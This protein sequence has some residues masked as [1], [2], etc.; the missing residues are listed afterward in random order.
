MSITSCLEKGGEWVSGLTMLTSHCVKKATDTLPAHPPSQSDILA[1][2]EKDP[3]PKENEREIDQVI[4]AARF[5]SHLLGASDSSLKGLGPKNEMVS[6]PLAPGDVVWRSISAS[7]NDDTTRL[8][9]IYLGN[10]LIVQLGPAQR[11]VSLYE[12]RTYWKAIIGQDDKQR[13]TL[14]T[15]SGFITENV[16]CGVYNPENSIPRIASVLMGA[17]CF[18]VVLKRLIRPDS[19]HIA[20]YIRT[21]VWLVE[22]PSALDRRIVSPVHFKGEFT[23][24][25]LGSAAPGFSGSSVMIKTSDVG[26]PGEIPNAVEDAFVTFE[27]INFTVSYPTLSLAEELIRQKEMIQPFHDPLTGTF[28]AEDQVASILLA[29]MALR[30][31]KKLTEEFV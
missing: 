8:F 19:Q 3:P 18:G 20:A 10:G 13:A 29:A 30:S 4:E 2:R 11:A 17:A 24:S 9:G 28:I 22:S 14:T 21:G 26:E 1:Q 5:K 6:W 12:G 31:D 15:P 27:T 23:K 16:R 7:P 25:K